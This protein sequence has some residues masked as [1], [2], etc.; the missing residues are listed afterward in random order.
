VKQDRAAV[1]PTLAEIG[2]VECR[3]RTV[4]ILAKAR[5]E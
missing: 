4:A 5:G 3:N 1:A 2:E